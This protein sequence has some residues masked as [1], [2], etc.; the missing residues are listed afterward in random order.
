MQGLQWVGQIRDL[1]ASHSRNEWGMPAGVYQA[2]NRGR[3]NQYS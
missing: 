1:F 3:I 2:K